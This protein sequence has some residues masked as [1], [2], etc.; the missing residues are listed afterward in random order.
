MRHAARAGGGDFLAW[1]RPSPCLSLGLGPHQAR[2]VRGLGVARAP[3]SRC[4]DAPLGAMA[5][6]VCAAV[7]NRAEWGGGML[8]FESPATLVAAPR[9]VESQ[10]PVPRCPGQTARRWNAAID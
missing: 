5:R 8:D 10:A 2:A 1:S 6:V 7:T 9:L 3:E 4:P